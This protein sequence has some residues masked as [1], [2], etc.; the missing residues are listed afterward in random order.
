MKCRMTMLL[1]FS[2]L[3]FFAQGQTGKVKGI[4]VEL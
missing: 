1:V 4:V 2:G 3:F